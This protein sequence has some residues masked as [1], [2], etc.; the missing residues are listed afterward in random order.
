MSVASQC[1]HRDRRSRGRDIAGTPAETLDLLRTL[2]TD[3]RFRRDSWLG[4]IFHH[5]KISFREISATDSLHILIDGSDVSAH[6]D[7]VSPLATRSDGTIRYAWGRVLAHNLTVLAADL[8]RRLRGHRGEHRCNLHCEAVWVDDGG[9]VAG[10]P[11]TP[12]AAA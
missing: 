2:E 9:E 11:T 5:G 10:G 6:V 1:S 7:D 3:A 8:A 12:P 4:A